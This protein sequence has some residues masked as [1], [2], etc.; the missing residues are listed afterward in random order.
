MTQ[1][2]RLTR[3]QIVQLNRIQHDYTQ[4]QLPHAEQI[5]YDF[6]WL[7]GLIARLNQEADNGK[8]RK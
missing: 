1:R 7:V 3:A 6:G 8:T 4:D 5:R 2:S